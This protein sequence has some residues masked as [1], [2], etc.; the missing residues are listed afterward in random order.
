MARNKNSFWDY[1]LGRPATPDAWG[2]HVS[3]IRKNV[4]ARSR[5]ESL[6]DLKRHARDFRLEVT[7]AELL[8]IWRAFTRGAPGDPTV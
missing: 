2:S 7:D 4:L 1:A 3:L 8:A 5:I 6:D